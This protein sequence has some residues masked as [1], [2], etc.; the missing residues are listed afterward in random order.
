MVSLHPTS[1]PD[2]I[3]PTERESERETDDIL[4]LSYN[5]TEM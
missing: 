3:M 5:D 4:G 1:L 2:S